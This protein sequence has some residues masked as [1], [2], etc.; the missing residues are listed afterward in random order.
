M[1]STLVVWDDAFAAYDFGPSHPLRPLRLE[2]TMALAREVGVLSGADVRAPRTAGDETLELVHDPLYVNAVRAGVPGRWGLGTGDVPAD[3]DRV[4]VDAPCSGIGT[5][6]R[7]PEIAWTRETEDVG[8]LADLQVA[9]T[10]SAATRVR[11]GGR[12]VYAV[13]SVLTE[14]C[15]GVVARLASEGDGRGRKLLPVPLPRPEVTGVG[16][17]LGHGVDPTEPAT[18][19]RLLPHV[20]GTDGY[21]VAAFQVGEP[22]E[23]RR[24]A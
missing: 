23:G 19:A 6:R 17:D 5:L 24:D 7:R 4:L 11:T 21:F 13:C 20:H 2:L 18:H 8:R 1:V 12:L 9:V 22:P 16:I 3:F 14:E 15:E 10:R